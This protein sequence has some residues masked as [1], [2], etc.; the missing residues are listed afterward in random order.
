MNARLLFKCCL[1]PVAK[2]KQY[3][4]WLLGQKSHL[5]M[6]PKTKTDLRIERGS[7]LVVVVTGFV[8]AVLIALRGAAAAIIGQEMGAVGY[9]AGF[10]QA[11][12]TMSILWKKRRSRFL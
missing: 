11:K 12:G 10:H 4:H 5:G 6:E 1:S 3:T 2:A 8:V 7:E 9:V